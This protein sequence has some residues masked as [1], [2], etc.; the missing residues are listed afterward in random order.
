MYPDRDDDR[1]LVATGK[2]VRAVLVIGQLVSDG[3]IVLFGI[4]IEL[5]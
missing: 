1:Y 5:A 2:L 3:S 4:E